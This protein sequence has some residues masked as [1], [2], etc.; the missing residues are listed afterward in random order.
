MPTPYFAL[1][2]AA[3]KLS[4]VHMPSSARAVPANA[5]SAANANRM[6]FMSGLPDRHYTIW[7]CPRQPR[8]ARLFQADLAGR[9]QD[10]FGPALILLHRPGDIQNLA[11]IA[12]QIGKQRDIGGKNRGHETVM[13]K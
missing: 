4:N 12:G 6:R 8:R 13:G 11:V 10:D 7:T 3:G 9:C 2:A 5:S 1:T